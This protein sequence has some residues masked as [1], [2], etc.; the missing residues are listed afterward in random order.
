M[1]AGGCKERRR[2]AGRCS[3]ASGC[4]C[5]LPCHAPLPALDFTPPALPPI[6]LLAEYWRPRDAEVD[7]EW[8]FCC[9][10][11]GHAVPAANAVQLQTGCWPDVHK[12]H[13]ALIFTAV[14]CACLPVSLSLSLPFDAVTLSIH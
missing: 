14:L 6:F 9:R 2:A 4:S 12:L 5:A 8:P 7:E 1:T 11:A 13:T 10:Q 3:Q